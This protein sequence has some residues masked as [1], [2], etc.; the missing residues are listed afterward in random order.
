MSAPRFP[1]AEQ[2]NLGLKVGQPRF[3]GFT[4][5]DQAA[6]PLARSI[7]GSARFLILI[8]SQASA[9]T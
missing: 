3:V 7:A 5:L 9:E 8:Q 4:R 1:Q 6:N 2:T